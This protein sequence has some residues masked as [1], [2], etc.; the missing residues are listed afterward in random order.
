MES[1]KKCKNCRYYIKL[2]RERISTSDF[3]TKK[4]KWLFKLSLCDHYWNIQEY[5]ALSAKLWQD[6]D[7]GL[8]SEKDRDEVGEHV[9]T[10]DQI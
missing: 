8:D 6:V 1:E 5:H 4:K 3:C 7:L 9:T 2:S 10:W